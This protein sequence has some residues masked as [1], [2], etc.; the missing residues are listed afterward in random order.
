MQTL[1]QDLRYAARMLVKKPGFTLIAVATL[2]IGIGAN[3][4]IFSVVNG[5]LLRSLPYPRADELVMLWQANKTVSNN[6]VSHL[7]FVDWRS[8]Q[9]SFAAISAYSGRWGGQETIIGGNEPERAYVVSVYRDFFEVLGVAPIVGRTFAPEESQPGTTPV[10]VVSRGFWERQLGHVSDL[11]NKK[12]TIAG[13]SFNVIGVMPA[14]FSF[15]RDTDVWASKE[16]LFNDDSARSSHN[17]IGIARLQSGVTREQ[18][19]AEMT[20]IANRI[21]E[22]DP[23]D[24]NYPD[25]AVVSLKD[26][27]TGSIRPA[28]LLLLAAVGCVLLIAC[29][30]VG[31]L[32]L[33]RALGRQRE[34]SIR[35]ALGAGRG[36]IVRQLLTESLLLALVGGAVGLLLAYWLVLALIA[37]GPT[38]I[39]RLHEI[40]VDS[41]TLGFT[42]AISLLT[43][44]I[45]GLVPALRAAKPDLS[46]MLKEGGR[47][48]STASGFVRSTLVVAEVSLTLVILVGAGLL[49]KSLW[50]VLEV[51]PG[52]NPEGV[53]TMQLSLPQSEYGDS[54][55]KISFYEQLLERMRSVPGV[56]STG[57]VNDLPMG[58]VDI[59]GALLIS[60]RP[61]DQAG[62]A[63]FRVVSP[64]YFRALNIPLV[65]GRYFSEQD[66]ESAEPVALISRRV[67]ETSFANEDPIGKR[68]ISTNDMSSHEEVNH[69]EKWPKII[70][71]VGDT[72]FQA[73]LDGHCVEFCG[74]FALIG[75]DNFRTAMS[76]DGP[77]H[78]LLSARR[79]LRADPCMPDKTF[80]RL[81]TNERVRVAPSPM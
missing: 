70:G 51:N 59:N 45:F 27:L 63:S 72:R 7:N 64:D 19:Q 5:V 42:L 57:M 47:N 79:Q 43:S 53:L 66:N 21:V 71:I 54:K 62:Y 55:R 40:S 6:P 11:S 24:K 74:K 8:Q 58:G 33:A 23:S 32:M 41:R 4:A 39:P 68:V 37:L 9:H 69:V 16:Q 61:L 25:A 18:A 1:L 35:T 36:R 10:V 30:N 31:N 50:R 3:A 67:A 2:A 15:P 56:Q 46:G 81:R 14:G 65:R 28:L 13:I 75:G 80:P 22:Q 76:D 77:R 60:G 78:A 34:M 48:V 73:G 26:Q 20:A 38:A 12:L 52:F 17:F 44:V 49:V 29:A